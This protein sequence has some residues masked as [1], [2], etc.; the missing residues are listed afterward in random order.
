[1]ILWQKGQRRCMCRE[2]S[3]STK[4][5]RTAVVPERTAVVP[6]RNAVV[7]ER[8]AAVPDMGIARRVS[9]II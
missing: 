2:L 3:L 5:E 7:P 1:M 9:V 8:N 6:E 4:P